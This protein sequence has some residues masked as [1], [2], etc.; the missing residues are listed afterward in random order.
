VEKYLTDVLK[1]IP[2]VRRRMEGH[3]GEV[4]QAT[5]LIFLL[6]GFGSAIAFGFNL[7]LARTF[8]ADGTGIYYLS[9]TIVMLTTTLGIGGFNNALLRFVSA[10]SSVGDWAAVKGAYTKGVIIAFGVS[11]FL[12]FTLFA[13]SSWLAEKIFLKP[14][15]ENP[16]RFMSFTIIPMVFTALQ[17][18]SLR[19]IKRI[20]DWI[21]VSGVFVPVFSTIGLLIVR[22]KWGVEGAAISLLVAVLLNA[23]TGYW[24][25]RK[26]T[27]QLKNIVGHFKTNELFQSGFPMFLMA[28]LD[29]LT[30]WAPTVFLGL[31]GS[32]AEVGVFGSAVRMASLA[33]VILYAFNGISAPKFAELYKKKDLAALGL[34]A[35]QT[36]KLMTLVAGPML[37][38]LIFFPK[39]IMGFLGSGFSAGASIL[40]IL[41]IGQLVNVLTGSVGYLLM[42]SG[43]EKL[44][45]N[46]AMVM[47]VIFISLNALFI[48]NYGIVGA[49]IAASFC[50]I[51][52]NLTEAY[53]VRLKLGIWT[54][55]FPIRI[56]NKN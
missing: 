37:A 10:S 42:M 38:L 54:L 1:K 52:T 17:A 13:S 53:L 16:L 26:S 18:E 22:K 30:N 45:R 46:R 14:E 51:A 2:F 33:N 35:R 28:L 40:V 15:L 24:F 6:R 23:G 9:L 29:T 43:N 44:L 48:R 4:I 3:L 41:T 47:S 36:T 56:K 27:P 32:K 11:T 31:W 55:P 7:L 39:F 19:G 25:W 20:Q 50:M 34:V 5:T 8:G 12:A 21:L 49:A